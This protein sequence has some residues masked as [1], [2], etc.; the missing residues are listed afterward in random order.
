MQQAFCAYKNY[1]NKY[2]QHL[3]NMTKYMDQYPSDSL[4]SKAM[5]SMDFDLTAKVL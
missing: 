2:Y 4:K 1:K 3:L 5:A